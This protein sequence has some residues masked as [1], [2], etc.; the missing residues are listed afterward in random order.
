MEGEIEMWMGFAV[1]LYC[2][3]LQGLG[4]DNGKEQWVWFQKEEEEQW[5]RFQNEGTDTVQG[6][7]PLEGDG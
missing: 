2:N 1:V 3:P 7:Y 5:V 6:D 4:V